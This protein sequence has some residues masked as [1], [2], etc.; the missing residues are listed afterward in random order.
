MNYTR[1]VVSKFLSAPPVG[2]KTIS[3]SSTIIERIVEDF[4]MMYPE[5]PAVTNISAVEERS[6]WRGYKSAY[7]LRVEGKMAS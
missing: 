7:L 1:R 3:D 6:I 4:H 5:W 2:Q